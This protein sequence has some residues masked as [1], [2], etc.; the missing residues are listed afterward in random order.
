MKSTLIFKILSIAV[1]TAVVVLLG[2]E[3]YRYFHQP[4]ATSVAYMGQFSESIQTTG[5]V[6]R[7]EQTLPAS[8]GTVLRQ[9]AEGEKVR[10]GQTIAVSYGSKS[11]LETVGKLED[12]QLKLQQLEFALS[13]FLDSDAALKVD[14]VVA[15][16]IIRLHTTIACGNY[17][18][19]ADEM[20]EVKTSVLKRSYSYES[21]EEIEAAITE[22]KQ[23]ITSLQ[24]SLSGAVA[25]KAPM[26]GVYSASCDGYESVLSPE[27]LENLTP[28]TLKGLSA[29]STSG[30]SGKMITGNTWYYAVTLPEETAS[31]MEEGQEVTLRFSKGL[32]Q[33][34]PAF[35]TIIS[36]SED[37][38][39]AV[40]FSCTRYI[41]QVTL[42][43]HQQGEI[44]LREYE[45]IHV[46]ASALRLDEEGNP[47]VFCQ[48][49]AYAVFKPVEIVY[50]G[51]GYYLVEAAVGTQGESILR[52]ADRVIS[53][54]EKLTDGM[55][56]SES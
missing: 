12:A 18:G 6:I 17:A 25:V 48:V 26:A 13:S 33:D 39:V 46:P 8:S 30:C 20:S 35:V 36:K 42:L 41:A 5:W 52:V 11:D 31:Q 27:L 43:R 44:L 55:I 21:T 47:G 7:Q 49:G 14:S 3:V 37:G 10:S 54:S 56:L 24:N 2:I 15:D 1:L 29:A 22:T 9:V 38:Q 16:S 53:T 28:S 23:T 51:E 19:A 50:R 32:T 40:V 4:V 45:G 34:C